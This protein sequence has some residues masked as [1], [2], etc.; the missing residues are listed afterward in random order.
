MRSTL[1]LVAAFAVLVPTVACA[2]E[3]KPQEGRERWSYALGVMTG[4]SLKSQGADIDPAKY[5]AGFQAAL[6]GSVSLTPAEVDAA[7]NEFR[8]AMEAAQ[9]RQRAAA[10]EENKL[11]GVKFL[12][13][14]KARAGV[15]TTA[16]G[17]QYEVLTAGTGP[18]PKASDTVTVHYRGTLIDGTEFD[19]SIGRGQPAT[20]GV[21]QVI[22]GWTEALQLM[23][24]GSKWKLVIPSELGYGERGAG[25]SIGPGAVLIF[26]VELL[27][28]AG[29]PAS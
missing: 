12:E 11:A 25:R 5:I 7:V 26:E 8:V 15:T 21:G 28:I 16:S 27:S 14:N 17:L 4:N 23:P 10:A 6:D 9:Q 18:I 22:K 13:E 20:F 3:T 2:E 1:M 19:S 24:V 29:A